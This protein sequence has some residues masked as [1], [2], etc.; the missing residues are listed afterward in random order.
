MVGK[1][2]GHKFNKIYNDCR[3]STLNK[4][5]KEYKTSLGRNFET[6]PEEKKIE[7][8]GSAS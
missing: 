1:P 7:T 4:S 5:V 8:I 2:L 6:N 3:R